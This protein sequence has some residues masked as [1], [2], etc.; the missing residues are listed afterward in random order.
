MKNKLP[1]KASL[2]YPVQIQLLL[3]I[4]VMA[5]VA[6]LA[7][8]SDMAETQHILATTAS[9][10]KEQCNRYARI[11]LAAETKSLM[12]SRLPT[13]LRRKTAASIRRHWRTT[14]ETVMLPELFCWVRT[15]PSF[16]STTSVGRCRSRFQ[17][18]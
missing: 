16:P 8:Q 10:I 7:I 3:G 15:E 12:R 9:Y 4:A 11:E 13:R 2:K 14:L 17:R 5:I 1:G 6:A 18:R